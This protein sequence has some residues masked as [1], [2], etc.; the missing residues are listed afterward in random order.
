[1][2][3]SIRGKCCLPAAAAWKSANRRSPPG[4]WSISARQTWQFADERFN[5]V[6]DDSPRSHPVD[7]VGN[8]NEETLEVILAGFPKLASPDGHLV[9]EQFLLRHQADRCVT[10][11]LISHRFRIEPDSA[12]SPLS[13]ARPP[14]TR[15]PP[16]AGER[17]P[18]PRNSSPSVWGAGASPPKPASTAGSGSL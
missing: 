15:S 3:G 14:R 9:H 8:S 4:A 2:R 12:R 10:G 17:V 5:G 7:C 18:T 1:M 11:E 13:P 6:Q 16:P